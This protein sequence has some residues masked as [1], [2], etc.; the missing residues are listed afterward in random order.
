MRRALANLLR[1]LGL[2]R[3]D[4]LARKRM[5]YPDLTALRSG[6]LVLVEDAGVKK[7]VCLR[8]PGGCGQAISLSLNPDRRPRWTFKVDFWARPS[9]EPSVHQRNACGCHFWI[10]RGRID[11]CRD[12]R[13]DRFEINEQGQ[14]EHHSDRIG[15]RQPR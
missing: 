2:L 9:V 3:F 6:D 14:S 11:W 13:P 5:D 12:G 1:F 10:R 15:G 8:C 4:L 7:W